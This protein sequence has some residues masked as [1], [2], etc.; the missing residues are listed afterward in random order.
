VRANGV[1]PGG[2]ID[3]GALLAA[4]DS[5]DH[6]HRACA[7]A[8]STARFPLATTSAVLAE[9]FYFALKRGNLL[10]PTWHIRTG[11]FTLARITDA[12]LPALEMLM[13][14]YADRPMDFADATLVHVAEREGLRTILTID[15][16]DFETYRIGRHAKFRILPD[17]SG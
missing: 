4:V 13:S 8:L 3:T 1:R 11:G 2:L 17:R 7:E 6:W 5:S 15:H 12:D 10:R 9:T 14:R 16:D